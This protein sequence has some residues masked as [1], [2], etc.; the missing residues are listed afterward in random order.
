MARASA[1][2][3]QLGKLKV[4]G[5]ERKMR[6][7]GLIL[8][9]I[10]GALTAM[11][12]PA[13][14]GAQGQLGLNGSINVL[15]SV[16]G[17]LPDP[18]YAVGAAG[19]AVVSF[20]GL[21]I[22]VFGQLVGQETPAGDTP[23][24][25][26]RLPGMTLQ[27]T[28]KISIRDFLE[29]VAT[30]ENYRF[31]IEDSILAQAGDVT[32][33]ARAAIGDDQAGLFIPSRAFFNVLQA[34]LK[35]KRLIL[36][37]F[38][39]NSETSIQFYEILPLAQAISSTRAEDVVVLD[40]IDQFTGDGAGFVTLIAPMRFAEINIVRTA[41]APFLT[42]EASVTPIGGL[43]AMVIA[44]YASNVR[45][46]AK[47]ISLMDVPP[48]SPQL[49][50]INIEHL[51]AEELAASIDELLN[52]R[53]TLLTQAGNRGGGQPGGTNR[54]P[55]EL[56]TITLAPTTNSLMVQGYELG[57]QLIKQLVEKLDVKVPG[58]DQVTGKIHIYRAR[59]V[60]ADALATALNNLLGN[61]NVQFGSNA[62]AAPDPNTGLVP[63]PPPPSANRTLAE[64]APIIE[65]YE[66]TNSLLIIAR[67]SVYQA[68]VNLIDLLD[69]RRHQVMIEAAILEV[70]RDDDFTF[71]VE[72]ASVDG[73][74]SGVRFSGGTSFGFSD[75]V[76]STG[77]PVETGGGEPAGRS[78]IFGTGGIF[79][80]TKG[81][82][83]NIPLL[84]RFLK[85]QTDINVLSVPRVMAN[86]NEE[87]QIDITTEIPTST[88]NNLGT[89]QGTQVTQSGFEEDGITLTVTPQINE[90]NYIVLDIDLDVS[91]F[92]GQPAQPGLSPPRTTRRIRTVV[93]VPNG[94]TVVI[95]GLTSNTS[96]RSVSKVPFL[97]DIPFVGELFKS[98]TSQDRQTNLYIFVRP[99]IYRDASF[100]DLRDAS[101]LS[102]REAKSQIVGTQ[103]SERVL[104][105]A[106]DDY[107]TGSASLKP[108]VARGRMVIEDLPPAK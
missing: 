14:A 89:G 88:L 58:T 44:D 93:T 40:N 3:G 84:V 32:I 92:I 4:A 26:P 1:S 63:P 47:I 85:Q 34:M 57:I 98:E 100:R 49:A 12:L 9:T 2:R 70:R 29:I 75:I 15:D 59:N 108:G 35:T 19:S 56:V 104:K 25:A 80:L 38:G 46:M 36:V 23:A 42:R 99:E 74:G 43:N 52:A 107:E 96:S 37:P 48:E 39:E 105:R 51:D 62:S 103:A 73:A 64:Q 24:Q 106:L 77:V 13:K 101:E 53:T 83:F 67:P 28:V 72:V 91:A 17:M 66:Q 21:Q 61:G 8:C 78:P 71:G 20:G 82:P 11:L 68:L 65:F 54:D 6:M 55:S 50:I 94:Q 10:V 81:G 22:P 31:L 27:G 45:R 95:G 33:I 60:Q 102:L 5:G 86:D 87:S 79:T 76:D 30:V 41:L 16:A 69:Q 90:D 18:A 97:G 7:P